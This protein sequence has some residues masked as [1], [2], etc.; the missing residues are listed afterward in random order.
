MVET[1]K[2][3]IAKCYRVRENIGMM[4]FMQLYRLTGFERGDM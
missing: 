4:L 3:A 2:V 1:M